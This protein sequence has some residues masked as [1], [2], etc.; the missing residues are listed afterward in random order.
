MEAR[1]TQKVC[2]ASSGDQRRNYLAWFHARQ[3][4]VEP[5]I[6]IRESLVVDSEQ[7]QDRRVEIMDA[8]RILDDVVG[9]VVGLSVDRSGA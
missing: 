1:R 5:L 7:P 6:A 3:S 9:E 8:H 2:R 4:L